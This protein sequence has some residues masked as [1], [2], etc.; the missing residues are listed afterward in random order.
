MSL[1]RDQV[2]TVTILVIPSKIH[3]TEFILGVRM[4]SNVLKSD[5]TLKQREVNTVMLYVN[6]PQIES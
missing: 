5:I 2:C 6:A 3:I 4:F 1:Q